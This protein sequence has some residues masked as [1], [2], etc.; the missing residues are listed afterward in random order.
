MLGTR[1]SE[2]ERIFKVGSNQRSDSALLLVGVTLQVCYWRRWQLL[3]VA[4][5]YTSVLLV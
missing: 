3:F 4:P 5:L 1:I 2:G